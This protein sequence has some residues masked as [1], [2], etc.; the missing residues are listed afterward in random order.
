[1]SDR[2]IESRTLAVEAG[3]NVVDLPVTDD[4]GAGAYVTATLSGRW[5]WPPAATRRARSASP[6]RRSIRGQALAVTF[7]GAGEATPRGVTEA[8]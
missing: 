3:D 4:W 6:R 5:T 8:V 1:M 2:L 7:E